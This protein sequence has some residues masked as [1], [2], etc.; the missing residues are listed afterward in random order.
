M[1][2][3]RIDH[4]DLDGLHNL[5]VAIIQQAM[6]DYEYALRG[7]QQF[8]TQLEESR[9]T[10]ME[11]WFL[12]DY[13]QLLCA[14]CGVAIIETVRKGLGMPL[15]PRYGNVRQPVKKEEKKITPVTVRRIGKVDPVVQWVCKAKGDK[16][17]ISVTVEVDCPVDGAQ[18]V[19]EA[20]AMYLERFGDT[21]VV[22]VRDVTP[23]QM[24]IG[25][26]S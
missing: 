18:A 10:D 1:A 20:L 14:G 8:K 13:G 11:D 5:Q 24:E 25:G 19:K 16:R 22:D 6:R 4:P 26:E 17:M 9:P 2:R 12:S 21:R 3:K 23:K 15:L 7:K